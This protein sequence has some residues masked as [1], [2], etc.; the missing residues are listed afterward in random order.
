MELA[1]RTSANEKKTL[2]AR[3]PEVGQLTPEV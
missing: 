3:L 1:K 2:A